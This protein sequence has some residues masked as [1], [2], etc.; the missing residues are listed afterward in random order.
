M[1][2]RLWK[3][4]QEQENLVVEARRRAVAMLKT[5]HEMFTSVIQALKDHEAGGRGRVADIDKVINHE[6]R[7]VRRMVFEHL[8]LSSGRDLLEG[9]R[10]VTVV[11]D[12]ERIG[13]IS[14]NIEELFEMF[15]RGIDLG[16]RAD[17][18]AE[19]ERNALQC[20][21]QTLLCFGDADEGA[22]REAIK[23]YEVV[24]RLCEKQLRD[25]MTHDL[26][27][28]TVQRSDLGLVILLRYVK[29]TCGHLK[30]ISS[31]V[32]NPFDR[33]GFKDGVG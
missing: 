21:E 16:Q 10:L 26:E 22:G 9:L 28:D 11:I 29:R 33:I 30:N 5:T 2:E 19:I 32:V 15:P 13:D 14:K 8:A 17:E 1:L 27:K 4:M 6:Q 3:L 12:I 23:H 7:A 24:A 18:Y 31:A 20:F 25:V